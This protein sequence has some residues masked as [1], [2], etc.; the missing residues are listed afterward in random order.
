M[1]SIEFLSILRR[2][3]ERSE[4]L[5]L[6]DVA[7]NVDK[8]MET[9]AQNIG[10]GLEYEAGIEG[11]VRRV[12]QASSQLSSAARYLPARLST[13]RSCSYRVSGHYRLYRI[14]RYQRE[15]PPEP[16]R[17]SR[18]SGCR[19]MNSHTIRVPP[20]VCPRQE[21]NLRPTVPETGAL[22]TE[23]RRRTERRY[24]CSGVV[25]DPPATVTGAPPSSV[26]S[27]ASFSAR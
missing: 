26:R 22:S 16:R 11:P 5:V 8:F 14:T 6:A 1:S 23:L 21:S 27:A 15:K 9:A 12:A 7:A 2:S 10:G 24:H 18:T 19:G 4:A 13:M 3:Q 20:C 25:S 17:L